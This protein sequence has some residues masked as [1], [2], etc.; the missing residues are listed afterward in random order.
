M[1]RLP[2][3]LWGTSELGRVS[4]VSGHGDSVSR[5]RETRTGVGGSGL[6]RGGEGDP[7]VPMGPEE[8]QGTTLDRRSQRESVKGL[9]GKC[10]GPRSKHGIFGRKRGLI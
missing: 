7:W 6:E 9:T 2:D 4:G 1:S 10:S 3:S 8:R 5:F